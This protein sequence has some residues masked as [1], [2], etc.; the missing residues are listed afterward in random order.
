MSDVPVEKLLSVA[1]LVPMGDPIDRDCRW[2]LN[3]MLWGDPGI[4]KSDRVE[5]A[6][7]MCCLPPRTVYAATTQPEDVSGAAFP[8]T[9]KALAMFEAALEGLLEELETA[10]EEMAGASPMLPTGFFDG[11]AKKFFKPSGTRVLKRVLAMAKKYGS[12]TTSLEPLLP[13]IS[14]LMTDRQGVLFLDELSC[15]RPAVQGAYLGVA[16]TRRVGGRQLPGGVRIMAAGNPPE[17]AAGG[18]ELEPPMANRFCHFEVKVPTIDEW[19][20]WLIAESGHRLDPIEDGELR[21]KQKWGDEWPKVKGLMAGFMKSQG[22]KILHEIPKDGSKQRG[23][24]WPSP[25]TWVF[26]AR[27]ITTCRCLGLDD[28]VRDAFVEGCVGAGAATALAA[29]LADADVPDPADMIAN[30]WEPDKKRLDR[31]IA[32]YTGLISHVNGL[33]TKEKKLEA[34]PGAWRCLRQSMD[35]GMFDITLPMAQ[36]LVNAGLD[37]KSSPE[38]K[39]ELAPIMTRLAKGGYGNFLAKTP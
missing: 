18:W 9:S 12:A 28:N 17:S 20:D 8:N 25:R 5:A 37:S 3:V 6:A 24:A 39:A 10:P 27:A 34:G 22:G 1:F 19:K 14:D 13:G 16:L 32:A 11:I 23:R 2:G 36:S 38:I 21:I 30:G 15:A 26:A 35:A 7:A 4:G 31:T 33:R 29:W